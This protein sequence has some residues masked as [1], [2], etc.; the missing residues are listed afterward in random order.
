MNVCVPPDRLRRAISTWF[1]IGLVLGLLGGG[2]FA[3]NTVA[4]VAK[5]RFRLSVMTLNLSGALPKYS[6]NPEVPL[7]WRDRYTRISDGFKA[8]GIAPDI[9][10]L[11]EVT[12]RKEWVGT[13]DPQ[14]YESLHLL[15]SNLQASIGVQYRIAY[16]GAV[17]SGEPGLIQGQAIIYNSARLKNV[18]RTG[19][20]QPQPGDS[21]P[22]ALGV[23]PR[24][25]YPCAAPASRFASSCA[26]LDGAGS[27]WTSVY[28][29]GTGQRHFETGHVRFAF[30]EDQDEQ[31]NVYNVHLHPDVAGY[32]EALTALV[33]FIEAGK[34]A[35]RP[36]YP[37]IVAGDFNGG[38][39]K[40]PRFD[41][42]AGSP[43]DY[44]VG[45]Q[46]PPYE[47]AYGF[48]VVRTAVL[49][50]AA[51]NPDGMCAPRDIAWSDHCALL[52]DIE[53]S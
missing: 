40:L 46:R 27:Y 15:I 25:S 14:D 7:P 8:L 36:V 32:A 18:T 23:G 51:A 34:P 10:A 4:A 42:L 17:A 21:V 39:E 3:C 16:L 20:G 44:V 53:P 22:S 48:S 19:G 5:D 37:P 2:T 33:D 13:R 38:T 28:A 24:N 49:P 26:L 52:A 11:Q 45:G 9:I 1:R 35:R 12:A 31:F 50:G 43:I 41:V 6:S 47:A 29:D 30:V